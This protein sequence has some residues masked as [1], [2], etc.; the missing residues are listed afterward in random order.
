[1]TF[2]LTWDCWARPAA[3]PY[4]PEDWDGDQVNQNDVDDQDAIETKDTGEKSYADQEKDKF[5]AL[6]EENGC[7][8]GEYFNQASGECV[9][10][11]KPE[12]GNLLNE[13]FYIKKIKKLLE[14]L[15]ELSG[16][17]S[18][19]PTY[20]NDMMDALSDK[21]QAQVDA[22]VDRM[23]ARMDI[24]DAAF[25]SNKANLMEAAEVI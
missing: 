25:D 22:L 20:K 17:Q 8:D 3:G 9:E 24:M 6:A 14:Y 2:T 10:T 7:G 19:F 13:P 16:T 5:A 4:K 11:P 21:S 18:A 1:M 23:Q 15:F 12:D